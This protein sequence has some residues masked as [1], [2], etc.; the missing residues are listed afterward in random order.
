M[1]VLLQSL[2]LD[3][4]QKHHVFLEFP[5]LSALHPDGHNRK[6]KKTVTLIQCNKLKPCEQTIR[7]LHKGGDQQS[8]VDKLTLSL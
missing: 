1:S 8:D 7:C 6:E 3:F 2:L 4:Q 5:P